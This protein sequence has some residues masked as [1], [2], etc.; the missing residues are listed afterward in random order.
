M[1][2]YDI[3]HLSLMIL[4]YIALGLMLFLLVKSLFFQIQ[5][6]NLCE[7]KFGDGWNFDYAI[8]IGNQNTCPDTSDGKIACYNTVIT[9][10]GSYDTICKAIKK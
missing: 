7:E 10:N 5:S 6:Q 2:T 1:E 4:V 3:L 8:G 9:D